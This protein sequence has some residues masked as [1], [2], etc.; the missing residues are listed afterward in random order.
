MTWITPAKQSCFY[1][2]LSG[3]EEAPWQL[4]SRSAKLVHH[5]EKDKKK[6][7]GVLKMAELEFH[8]NSVFVRQ[9]CLWNC[10]KLVSCTLLVVAREWKQ[11]INESIH[12]KVF[13][14]PFRYKFSRFGFH[15]WSGWLD[16]S[17]FCLMSS[18]FVE[19]PLKIL[20]AGLTLVLLYR[21]NSILLSICVDCVR[22]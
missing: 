12:R 2:L 3:T 16:N 21:S 7:T 17:W 20:D 4:S 10:K 1:S 22:W 9:G 13:V 5:F 8:V 18:V 6:V 15:Y 14:V 19:S 11:R